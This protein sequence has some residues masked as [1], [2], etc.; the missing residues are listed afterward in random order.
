MKVYIII[1][2][3]SVTGQFIRVCETYNDPNEAEKARV[4]FVKEDEKL[5]DELNMDRY[6]FTI[7]E[8]TVYIKEV[9]E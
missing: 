8:S 1:A 7:H 3:D 9:E 4:Q 2:T 5:S 6:R